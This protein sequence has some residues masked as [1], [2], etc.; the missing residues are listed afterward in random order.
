[1]STRL[2]EM[3]KVDGDQFG[4]SCQASINKSASLGYPWISDRQRSAF[5]DKW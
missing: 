3:E 1:M 2:V 4:L 5:G